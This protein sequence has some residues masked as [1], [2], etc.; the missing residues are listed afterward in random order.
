MLLGITLRGRSLAAVL[1]TL[2][3]TL[4]PGTARAGIVT[5]EARVAASSDDAEQ[6]G[7]STSVSLTSSDLEL[8]TESSAQTVGMR[9]VGLAIPRGVTITD[10]WLQFQVDEATIDPVALTLRAQAADSAPTF[11]TAAN[12]VAGRATGSASVSW[13]PAPWPTVAAVG[14]DQRATGLAPLIQEVVNRPGWASGNALV[15][16]VT[17]SGVRTAEAF[18]GT[19][20]G[21]PL[22]HVAYDL[23]GSSLPPSLTLLGPAD[24]AMFSLG[25]A[26]TFSATASDPEDGDVTA[27]LG[28]TS[29]RDGLLGSGGSL[30]RSNLTAG[31]HTIT[32]TARD[33][34]GQTASTS[35]AIQV[36]SGYHVLVGAGDISRCDTDHDAETAALLDGIFGTVITL[37]DN[38]YGNGSLSE[39]EGCYGP[40]WGRQKARTRPALGNQE[41]DTAGAAG[42]FGYFGAAAGPAPDGYY[43]FDVDAWH[44][45]V[46]NAECANV[47]GGCARTS[48]QGQ[49]LAA[50]LAAHPNVCTL[51]ILHRPR[52]TATLELWQVLYEAGADVVLAGHQHNYERFAP[53]TPAGGVDASRGIRQFIVGTGG[54][55]LSPLGAPSATSVIGNDTSYGVLKLTLYPSSYDWQYLPAAGSTFADVGSSSCVDT[56]HV[57]ASPVV[58]ITAPA[59]GAAFRVNTAV[60]LS[61]TA[62]DAEDGDLSTSIRWSSDRS[63]FLGTGATLVTSALPSGTHRITATATDAVGGVGTATRTISIYVPGLGTTQ[64]RVASSADDAEERASDGRVNLTSNDLE[65]TFDRRDQVVG[66]RFPAVS[67]PR[68]STILDAY[69][70]F[71]VDEVSTG[72]TALAVQVEASDSAAPFLATTRNVSLRPRT[73]GSVSWSPPDWPTVGAAG[74]AQRTPN[75]ASLLQPVIDRSGWTP[76]QALAVIVSGTGWRVAESFEGGAAKAPLLVIQYDAP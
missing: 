2:L 21:A 45:V 42:Y 59:E 58:A 63:G 3:A 10:A 47:A 65:L 32:A 53:Q 7:G 22:L 26:V 64:H 61:A 25:Q 35:F 5:V 57:N 44:V 46:L 52:G 20:A 4:A 76:G 50:D 73:P 43:S 69:V 54:A 24:H 36:V 48:P 62:S 27:S 16:L 60:T 51:A 56:G 68:G 72:A 19:A 1:F 12:D 28:W 34:G 11:T 31:F 40:T 33:A 37:G 6:K 41:F 71:Q 14:L 75:L 8:V 39:F 23:P 29:S 30:V 17:G 66:L 38:T 67:V 74:T 13:S 55:E 15:L 70:Q 18:D 49:W 9:F